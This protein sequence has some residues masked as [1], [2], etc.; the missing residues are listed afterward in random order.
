VREQRSE[1]SRDEVRHV[2]VLARLAL[3]DD[4]VE[5]MRAE[6]ASILDQVA[7]LNELDTSAIPPSASILPLDTVMGEDEPRPS[8]EVA[9]VI[10]NAPSVEDNQFRVPAIL[11]E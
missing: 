9:T 10:A 3:T 11:E 2:A 4:E 8:L 5:R 1:L 7:T 6:M